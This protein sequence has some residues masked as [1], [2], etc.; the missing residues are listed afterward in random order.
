MAFAPL[1]PIDLLTLRGVYYTT[2]K[3]FGT[4]GSGIIAALGPNL[5][6][7]SLKVGDKVHVF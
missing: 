1:N 6:N 3:T 2:G 4:E 7:N 5:R